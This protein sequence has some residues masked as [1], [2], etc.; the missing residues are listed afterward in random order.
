MEDEKLV[1][2][3]PFYQNIIVP[4]MSLT[5]LEEEFPQFVCLEHPECDVLARLTCS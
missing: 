4:T 1:F 5:L 2:Y 3:C